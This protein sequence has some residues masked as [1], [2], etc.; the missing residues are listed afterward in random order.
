MF[1]DPSGLKRPKVDDDDIG[2]GGLR[3][4][5]GNAFMGGFGSNLNEFDVLA[6]AT[7]TY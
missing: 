2:G 7:T 1:T 4:I 6:N 3:R 5:E